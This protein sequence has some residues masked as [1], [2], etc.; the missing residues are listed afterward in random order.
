MCSV[1]SL[2]RTG[3]GDLIGENRNPLGMSESFGAPVEMDGVIE[4]RA[5]IARNPLHIALRRLY[6]VDCC[7]VL[8]L[9]LNFL[10]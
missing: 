2:G 9:G 6:Q 4:P 8:H 10:G 1:W 5:A 3:K 7:H